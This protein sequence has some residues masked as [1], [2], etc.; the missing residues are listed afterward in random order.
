VRSLPLGCIMSLQLL[1]AGP[2]SAQPSDSSTPAVNQ[3]ANAQSKDAADAVSDSAAQALSNSTAELTH[4]PLK[5]ESFLR[6]T[7][8]SL[9]GGA[10]LTTC[11]P[12]GKADCTNTYPGAGLSAAMEVRF[13]YLGLA[14]EYDFAWHIVGG[15]GSE[16]VS[17][18]TTHITPM[19][20]GY[21]PLELLEVFVGVG[22]GYSSISVYESR[23]ESRASWSTLW[24]GLKLSG[25]LWYDLHPWGMPDGFTLDVAAHLFLNFGGERCTEYAGSGPCLSGDDLSPDQRDVA[26]H[27]QLGSA[28]RYTF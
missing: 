7:G 28:L 13:W 23:S 10:A 14:L 1:L 25:G 19:L 4:S 22:L 3:A 6:R 17:S 18:T 5:P 9:S 24:Q 15:S 2:I 20:K 12:S 21:Y 27:L 16:D 26:N 11:L 8:F